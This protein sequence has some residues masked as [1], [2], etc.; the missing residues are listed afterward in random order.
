[1]AD[2]KDALEKVLFDLLSAG[3]DIG[4]E[5]WQD[6]PPGTAPPVIVIGD[7][8]SRPLTAAKNEKDRT[9]TAQLVTIA[10]GG[11]RK[12][13]LIL[14]GRIL[15]RCD[16]ADVIEDGWRITLSFADDLAQLNEERGQYVGFSNFR[17]TALRA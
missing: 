5:V 9:G 1:M 7:V 17:F 3:S 14:Q 8:T 2:A 10:E 13:L 4:A 15:D 6:I 12:P 11:E 16:G